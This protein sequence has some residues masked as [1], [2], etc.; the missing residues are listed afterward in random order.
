MTD[1]QKQKILHFFNVLDH[2][3]NGVLEHS[4]FEQVGDHI[5]DIIGH[6]ANSRER[7]LLRLKAHGLFIQILKDIDK[8]EAE[9]S[10]AEWVRFFE[11]AVLSKPNDYVN[12]SS[13]YL[14]SLFD[15]DGDGHIDEREYLDM[16]KAYGLYMSVAKKA[17]DMLDINGDG[18]ISGGELVKAF[19]DYF[20]SPD[21]KAP[22]NWIFGDWRNS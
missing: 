11:E 22:G 4:D 5:S 15:Q 16:F 1:V 8:D 7:L 6:S 3:G 17:F 14:F 21:E 18:R 20:L 9:L 13:T 2:N 10:P 19:E 12:Q